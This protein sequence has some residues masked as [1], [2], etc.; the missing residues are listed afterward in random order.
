MTLAVYEELTR[1]TLGDARQADVPGHSESERIL[2][3]FRLFDHKAD[4]D[5]YR[6]CPFIQAS[7]Q[8]AEPEGAITAVVRAYRRALRE[9][10]LG[11]L[12]ERR[13]DRP[14]L[15]DQI[16]LLLDGVVIEAY[17]KGVAQPA[18]SAMRAAEILMQASPIV[19]DG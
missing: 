8:D 12:D 1:T 19:A 3:L 14:E 18:R 4:V 16:L 5:G 6:G 11:I 10:I 9:H 13:A 15:A 2:A 7:L 17:L